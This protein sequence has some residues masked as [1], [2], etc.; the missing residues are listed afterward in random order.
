MDLYTN[1]FP[2]IGSLINESI[3][4]T[5]LCLQSEQD[6]CKAFWWQGRCCIEFL[7]SRSFDNKEIENCLLFLFLLFLL[8]AC[9]SSS[10]RHHKYMSNLQQQ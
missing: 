8:L 6:V 4:Q 5:R 7:Q 3:N 2:L 9:V 1:L 10:Q